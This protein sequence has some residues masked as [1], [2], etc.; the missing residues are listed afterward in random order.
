MFPGFDAKKIGASADAL[1]VGHVPPGMEAFLL[2][3]LARAGQPVAY[4]ISDGQRM[5]DLEQVLSFAAP[6]IPV[7]TLPAWDCLPYDRVSPSADTS[8]R[9]LAA[10]SGLAHFARQPHPAILIVTVNAMLQRVAP[11]EVVASSGF[12]AKP[13]N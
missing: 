4:V 12:S 10:L 5:A 11:R 8:A 9:R 7:L 6:G 2:A 3:E 1:T 13:G